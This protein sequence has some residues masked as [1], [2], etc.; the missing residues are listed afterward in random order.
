MP[1]QPEKFQ[2]CIIMFVQRPDGARSIMDIIE[3]RRP[4]YGMGYW[5]RKYRKLCRLYARDP[6]EAG[7]VFILTDG[8]C[9]EFYRIGQ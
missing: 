2:G 1:R 5:A 4:E 7:N 8:N 9:R 6:Q 3:P